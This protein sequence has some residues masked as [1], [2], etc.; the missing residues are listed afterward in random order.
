MPFHSQT[1]VLVRHAV[2]ERSSSLEAVETVSFFLTLLAPAVTPVFMLSE[3]WIHLP[4]G[5]FINCRQDT[6]REPT[7]TL[8]P[9]W[10]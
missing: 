6:E 5:C 8:C 2:N 10:L 3:R 9:L 7:G 4:C 1:L